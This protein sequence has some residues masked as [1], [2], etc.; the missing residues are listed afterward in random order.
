MQ[1]QVALGQLDGFVPGDTPQPGDIR[2]HTVA[3]HFPVP[4]TGHPVGDHPGKVQIRPVIRHAPGHRPEGLGHG[5]GVHQGGRGQAE[6]H[7][8]VGAAGVAVEQSHH[9]F[10]QDQVRL[11]GRFVE[12]LLASLLAHHPQVQLM[13][14]GAAGLLVDLG[15]QIVRTG[16]E[17]PHLPA[18]IP[19]VASQSR[20]EGGLALTGGRGA[21]QQGRAV[22]SIGPAH[23]G[24]LAG[25]RSGH[26]RA[27]SRLSS[28]ASASRSSCC[29]HSAR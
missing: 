3:Q 18:P 29:S 26:S 6:A 25:H 27:R 11:G 14:R 19:V 16:L 2:R 15:I 23:A 7:R 8:Q 1:P 22:S 5:P 21:H 9:P 28:M 4:R 13:D 24:A 20:H 17:H 10:H 12:Q